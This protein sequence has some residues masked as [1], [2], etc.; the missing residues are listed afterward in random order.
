MSVTWNT[1]YEGQ[2]DGDNSPTL[3][4]DAFREL[5]GAIRE[6]FEKEHTMD[7]TSGAFSGDGWH[8]A[9]S[10]MAYVQAAEPTTRPDAATALT[11]AIDKGRI[12]F[13]SDNGYMPQVYGSDGAFHG[14]LREVVR[15]SYQGTLV[16]GTAIVP[17]ITFPNAGTITRCI[18]RVGT[19][20]TGASIIVDINRYNSSEVSQGSIF[21]GA[22]NRLTIAAADYHDDKDDSSS[23]L[24]ATNK[25]LVYGDFLTVD[26]DQVG[27]TVAGADLSITIE[28]SLG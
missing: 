21:D 15:L 9:G 24:D 14:C 6:R 13:D 27:S 11:G 5:K 3:G 2:P 26:I 17:P 12:W 22:S 18:A 10:G 19:A 20:P 28:L 4:D 23:E 16:T 1:A 7:L 25:T 8:I